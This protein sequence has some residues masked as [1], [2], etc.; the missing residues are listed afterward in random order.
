[1]SVYDSD[2]LLIKW[3]DSIQTRTDN[4]VDKNSGLSIASEKKRFC[5][6]H[7][8]SYD[9]ATKQLYIQK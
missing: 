4:S 9:S 6:G 7:F 2:L 8:T 1:M 5:K 3:R